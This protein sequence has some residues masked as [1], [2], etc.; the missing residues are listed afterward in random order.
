MSQES[1]LGID[2]GTST[3]EI[4]YYSEQETGVVNYTLSSDSSNPAFPSY[5]ATKRDNGF[6]FFG[7]TSK[8][9]IKLAKHDVVYEMKRF[10]GKQLTH[11]KVKEIRKNKGEVL[12]LLPFSTKNCLTIPN[13]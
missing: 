13:K 6:E 5:Y 11:P 4:A 2:I 3:I 12:Q 9:K 1:Y 7:K 8:Y 10:I